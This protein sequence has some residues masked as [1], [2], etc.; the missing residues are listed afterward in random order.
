MKTRPRERAGPGRCRSTGG[1]TPRHSTYSRDSCDGHRIYGGVLL[2]FEHVATL[3]ARSEP[4]KA[5]FIGPRRKPK[6]PRLRPRGAAPTAR[7]S[8]AHTESNMAPIDAGSPP[9][10]TDKAIKR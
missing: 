5:G 8:G 2:R 6:G 3:R 9:P 4:R 7:T 1:R 10:R